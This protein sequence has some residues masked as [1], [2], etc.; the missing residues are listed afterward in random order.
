[1]LKGHPL[2]EH[3]RLCDGAIENFK[4]FRDGFDPAV[5]TFNAWVRIPAPTLLEASVAHPQ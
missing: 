3:D 1:L 5:L 2:I 4:V